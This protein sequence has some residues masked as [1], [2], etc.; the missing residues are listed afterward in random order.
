MH[1]LAKIHRFKHHEGQTLIY[2]T[3]DELVSEDKFNQFRNANTGY[4]EVDIDFKDNRNISVEQRKKI[5]AL[6]RDISRYNG[7]GVSRNKETLKND[8][9]V[10]KRIEPFSLSDT[11]VSNAREFISYLIEL[12]FLYDI[13]FKN[14]GIH[15]TDD[16]N[17][18]LYLC[19]KF[20]KCAITGVPGEVHHI[21][22]IGAGRDRRHVD[23]S[24][25]RL[26]C[27]SR[28]MHIKAHSMGWEEFAALHHIDGIRLTAEQVKGIKY[29]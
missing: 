2:A 16:I 11:S 5:Y 21:D 15:M 28:E 26:V 20:R 1:K 8:Y 29:K 6:L 12:C 19:L 18:Y 4:L 25:H 17:R 22:T 24:Q 7:H 10:E 3:I 27:L 23:H 9:I 13:P 14:K